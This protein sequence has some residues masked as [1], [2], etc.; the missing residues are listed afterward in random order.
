MRHIKEY[1]VEFV[2]GKWES[3]LET[4]MI[5]LD[6]ITIDLDVN[7]LNEKSFY[8][9]PKLNL[10][11]TKVDGLK[12]KYNINITRSEDNADYRVISEKFLE[13]TGR[14]YY[15][16]TYNIH[17]V[18]EKTKQLKNSYDYTGFIEVL[19]ELDTKDCL[20]FKYYNL[21][22][23]LRDI[24]R[25]VETVVYYQNGYIRISSKTFNFLCQKNNLVLDSDLIKLANSESTVLDKEQYYSLV[26]MIR[27]KDNDNI[28]V[29]LE[30]MANCNIEESLDYISL[31]YYF[32]YDRLK[33]SNNWNSVNVKALRNRLKSFDNHSSGSSSRGWYYNRYIKILAREN[34]LTKFAFLVVQ[35]YVYHNVVLRALDIGE[36]EGTFKIDHRS[37][38]LSDEFESQII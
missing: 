29:A 36:F 12:S 4:Y 34:Y 1:L 28:T 19:E 27:S 21:P 31:I 17:D 16:S 10:P 14:S 18:L 26:E 5:N 9:Y 35:K 3:D 22:D 15:W 13:L 23:D 38:K 6:H 7:N 33:Y 20:R 8:R 37:I 30:V 2:N 11:R 32:Y 25:D 24:C